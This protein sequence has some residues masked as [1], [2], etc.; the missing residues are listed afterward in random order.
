MSVPKSVTILGHK[1]VVKQVR[2]LPDGIDVDT[3]G[4]ADLTDD[5]IYLHKDLSD[6]AKK[7]ILL[8]EIFHHGMWKNGVDQTLNASQLEC[9][10][11]LFTYLYIEIKRQK[12]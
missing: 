10:C 5:V 2:S 6:T 4:L 8:H 11:Q 7:K 3:V 9:L 1:T 12:L